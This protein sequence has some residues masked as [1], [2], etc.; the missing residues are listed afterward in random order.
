MNIVENV[1]A[2]CQSQGVSLQ[3]VAEK[4]GVAPPSLSQILRG[5]PTL[6]K[7]TAIA[8]A[9]GVGVS[10]LLADGGGAATVVCPAC[11]HPFQVD[12]KARGGAE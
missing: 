12:V 4:I 7:L 9:L 5:N 8:G 1:K 2:I 3:T 11:G 6:S 10:D